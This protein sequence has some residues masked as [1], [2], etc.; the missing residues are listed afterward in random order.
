MR[1][2]ILS[3]A[4][5]TV[6][7]VAMA[8]DGKVEDASQGKWNLGLGVSARTGTYLGQKDKVMPFPVL[9]YEGERLFLRGGYGGLH[10]LNNDSFSVSAIVS[11]K[12]DGLDVKDMKES[13]LA[14]YGLSRSQ[15]EDRKMGADVGIEAAW[16]GRYGVLAAQALT[17]ATGAS[18]AAEAKL[19]YQYFW[20]VGNRWT[21]V[22]N[23]GLTWMSEKRA[24]YY[25]GTLDKEV[26]RGVASYK[27][28]SLVIPHLSLGATYAI[29]ADWKLTGVVSHQILPDKATA[30]PLIQKD[31]EG[32]TNIFVGVSRSF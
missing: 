27:P 8:Q 14:K 15:L 26:A 13:T 11:G 2:R 28:G 20:Q 4:I 17:D 5:L 12:F 6:P 31:K 3:V 32:V 25:Y 19:N 24:N 23:V 21:I 1:K 9:S 18:K 29:N 22:P 16:K 7:L 30:S 10:L